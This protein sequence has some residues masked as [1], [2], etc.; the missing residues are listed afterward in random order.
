MG[1]VY[2]AR[3]TKLNRPVA[4]KIVSSLLSGDDSVRHRLQKE[5]CIL[6]QLNHPNIATLY[7][8]QEENGIDFLVMEYI[9][10]TSLDERLKTGPMPQDEVVSLGGQLLDGL[11]AA[12][13]L[14]ILHRDLKPENVRITNDG[15]L[16]ILDFGLA[17]IQEPLSASATTTSLGTK[18]GQR[19]AGTLPYMSPEQLRGTPDKAS[20]VFSA[21]AV[22][23]EMSTGQRPFPEKN[24]AEL[25]DAILNREPP[26]PS[27]INQSSAALDQVILKALQKS[28]Q[29]RF[30]SAREMK[31][32]LA[33]LLVAPTPLR[34][35]GSR[36]VKLVAASVTIVLLL[37]A[38]WWAIH[39]HE[40]ST[41]PSAPNTL[42]P[43]ATV[44]ERPSTN[45]EANE[46]FQRASVLL[47]QQSDLTKPRELLE[48]A[49]QLDPHFAHARCWLAF[50]DIVQI[51]SGVSNDTGWLYKAEPELQRGLQDNPNS[52]RCH[53]ALAALYWY[54]IRM[55][56]S[57]AQAKRALELNP[58]EL[59]A[60]VWLGLMDAMADK[61]PQAQADNRE[62]LRRDPVYFAGRVGLGD[63]LRQI[64][65]YERANAEL[66]KVLDIDPTNVY[67][68][69]YLALS[70]LDSG[71]TESA[72][73]TLA[74]AK[75]GDRKN[76]QIRLAWALLFAHLSKTDDA[77]REMDLNLQ[78][79]AVGYPIET[80][81]VAEFYSLLGEKKNALD[82]LEKAL[83][84]G[85][86]RASW[87]RRDPLLANIRGEPRFEQLLA[88]IDDREKM[89]K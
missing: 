58:N 20:D 78:Q 53:S 64:G 79:Y 19:M 14:G 25:I 46:L 50:T 3:D 61:Y 6:S 12:H 83:R 4:I 66:R 55:D 69:Q 35:A 88:T 29:Q 1:V 89:Q 57:R 41:P 32:A 27:A 54:Q 30:K 81:Y 5:A 23:Y 71:D 60:L 16:K 65:E 13:Q 75:P 17:K 52:A 34:A 22:L 39:R 80:L 76:F 74:A 48:Q 21:G 51:D 18:T 45:S 24:P 68:I 11:E 33:A 62:I 84:N 72:K 26:P 31:S 70:Y 37:L 67:A 42:V 86:D 15:R 77:K 73:K 82:W 87:F 85:D 8:L 56:L 36:S 10:G 59:D 7:E 28:P 47:A 40:S 43:P 38:S 44:A 9:A 63:D 2:L 49:L